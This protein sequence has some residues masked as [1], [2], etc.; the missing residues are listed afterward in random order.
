MDYPTRSTDI[1]RTDLAD[2][3]GLI[4]RNRSAYRYIRRCQHRREFR[5]FWNWTLLGCVDLV[6][7]VI[8]MIQALMGVA[9]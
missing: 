5:E 3:D 8:I 2:R 7:L 6:C 1:G 4:D 9:A